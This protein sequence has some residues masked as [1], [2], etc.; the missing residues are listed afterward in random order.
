MPRTKES[1]SYFR[2]YSKFYLKDEE[3]GSPLICWRVEA[4][5]W[6][7]TPGILEITAV[8]YYINDDEDD[9]EKKIAGALITKPIDPNPEVEEGTPQIEGETFIKPRVVEEYHLIN[10]PT[11]TY[12]WTTNVDKKIVTININPKDHYHIKLLWNPTYSGQFVLSYGS[13]NKTIVVESLM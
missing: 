11:R 10:P 4:T 7:S 9:L 2:R 3:E 12:A 5:D 8:E 13:Y 1:L 6:I